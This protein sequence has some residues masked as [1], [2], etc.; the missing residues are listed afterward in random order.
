MCAF[1]MFYM[2][3]YTSFIF[4]D[5]FKFVENVYGCEY[6]SVKNFGLILKNKMATI[7]DCSN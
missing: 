6:M 2:N 3:L 7:V 4:E 5:I 1:V